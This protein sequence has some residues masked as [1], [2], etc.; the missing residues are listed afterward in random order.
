MSYSLLPNG[1][2]APLKINSFKWKKFNDKIVWDNSQVS[3]D[4]K[5]LKRN[6]ATPILYRIHTA[7][8]I[9]VSL[10]Q[11]RPIILHWNRR[12]CYVHH[13]VRHR[14]RWDGTGLRHSETA[15]HWVPASHFLRWKCR[16]SNLTA[17]DWLNTW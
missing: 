12:R 14:Y 10:A 3:W 1:H 7:S 8:S 5:V 16:C 15:S 6:L 13:S 2:Y 9:Y 11:S 17:I 4:Q